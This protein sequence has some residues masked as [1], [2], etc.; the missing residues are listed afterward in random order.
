[1]NTLVTH[2]GEQVEL[3]DMTSAVK[4]FDWEAYVS[5]VNAEE[6]PPEYPKKGSSR[7]NSNRDMVKSKSERESIPDERLEMN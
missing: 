3:K 4:E 7:P 6:I 5:V 2:A 1:M